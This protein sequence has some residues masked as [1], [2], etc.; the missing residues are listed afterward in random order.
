MSTFTWA[1]NT[2]QTITAASGDTITISGISAAALT[3]A[4]TAGQ[5]TLTGANGTLTI[6]SSAI[7]A[8]ADLNKFNL[9]FADGSLL[10]VLVDG[11][12]GLGADGN[13]QFIGDGVSNEIHGGN[14]NDVLRGEG[15]ND[16]I[17][18]N[19]GND[20]LEGGSGGNKLVGGDGDDHYI[21]RSRYDRVYDY[22]GNDSG[23][24]YASW[25]KTENDVENWTWAPGVEKLPY[26]IDGLTHG[27][28]G[29]LGAALGEGQIVRYHFP[30]TLPSFFS[31]E[32]ANGF[33]PFNADQIAYTKK[34]FDY[35]SS[36]IGVTFLEVGVDQ[37]REPFTV[38]LANNDQEN[39]GGYAYQLLEGRP[40]AIMIDNGYANQHPQENNGRNLYFVLM[41]EIGHVLG[42]KHPFE[43]NSIDGHKEPAPYLP[44]AEDND[45]HTVM[46]YTRVDSTRG[47]QYA[48]LDL[49]ALQYVYGP[50]ASL[51][52]EDNTWSISAT[53]SNMIGDGGGTD[54]LSGRGLTAALTAFLEPGYWGYVGEKAS[55]ISAAGQVVI[56]FGSHIENLIGGTLDDRLT[57]NGLANRIEGEQGND[58]LTGAGGNDTLDGGAGR[59]SALFAGPSSNFAITR[60]GA[61]IRVTDNTGTLGVDTLANIERIVFDDRVRAYDVDGN[62]G[63]LYRLYQASFDRVP[64]AAG[65]GFWLGQLDG[66]TSLNAIAGGFI[67]SSEFTALYGVDPTPEAY[68]ARLYNNVLHR[69]YEK[70]GYDFWLAAMKQ[71]GQ[72]RENVLLAFTDSSENIALVNPSIVDG[73]W[74]QPA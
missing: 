63:Q 70:A 53:S 2:S 32:D 61:N 73:F 18:G 27:D 48:P 44:K 58:R 14:G 29:G 65:I 31:T 16:F 57:G 54:T 35:I 37:A 36:V 28:A 9:T 67:A 6:A 8:L 7:A 52:P 56:N 60:D 30:Q 59:D 24:I 34:A 43:T 49:A 12:F 13:D 22:S 71:H 20:R 33:T 72:S 62:G 38:L 46:S 19:G 4:V 11:Y 64:D 26:W 17:Y 1:G 45:R 25:F 39:S 23:I 50:S 42:L 40:S 41:H 68:I 51:A 21:I 55:T 5:F 3:L 74:Y 47:M 66:G 10:S 15:G 69:P